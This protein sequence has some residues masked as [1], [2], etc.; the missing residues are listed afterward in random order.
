[1]TGCKQ[2]FQFT[3]YNELN[4][5]FGSKRYNFTLK[6]IEVKLNFADDVFQKE[7]KSTKQKLFEFCFSHFFLFTNILSRFKR[8]F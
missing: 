6:L 2:K 4:D 8:Y 1:M 7:T 3:T 5:W